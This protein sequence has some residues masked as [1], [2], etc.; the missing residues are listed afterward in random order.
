VLLALVAAALCAP[1][2]TR[3]HR[4][5]KIRLAIIRAN[6]TKERSHAMGVASSRVR[7][8]F[9]RALRHRRVTFASSLATFAAATLPDTRILLRLR[10]TWRFRRSEQL[11][12]QLPAARYSPR[13]NLGS[14]RRTRGRKREAGRGPD[15]ARCVI[16]PRKHMGPIVYPSG[17]RTPWRG[18][19]TAAVE[20]RA[21]IRPP[22]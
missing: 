11:R 1:L 4:D 22:L 6:D 17:A 7:C 8:R 20:I 15:G 19:F 14:N 12:Q 3:Q 2:I 10:S 16:H 9:C 18:G 21:K 5:G 13:R